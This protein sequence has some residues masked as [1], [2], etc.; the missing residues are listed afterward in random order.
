MGIGMKILPMFKAVQDTGPFFIVVI[1]C[2]SASTHAYYTIQ[3]RLDPWPFY[4][5]VM[6]ISRLGILGDFDLFEFEGEDPWLK[7]GDE[8]DEDRYVFEDPPPGDDYVPVHVLFWITGM[9]I[10]ILLMNL[11]IGVLSNAFDKRQE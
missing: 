6:Q 10:T 11:F 2:L 7:R 8:E 3:P 9:G 1:F 5:S 4:A